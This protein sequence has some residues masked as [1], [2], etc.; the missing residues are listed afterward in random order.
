MKP[1]IQPSESRPWL[2][3][4]DLLPLA[5]GLGL[6][7][8]TLRYWDRLPDPVP[9]HFGLHNVPNGWT[10]KASI[11]W[12]IFGFPLVMW[13]SLWMAG[14]FAAPKDP[15][16]AALVTYAFAPLRGL[17]GLG[18]FVLGSLV[19]LIPVL[20]MQVF[21]PLFLLFFALLFSGIG[22]TV[23]KGYL[24]APDDVKRHWKWGIFYINPEDPRLW[25]PKYLGI[26]WTLNFSRP[27]AW[28][29]LVVLLLTP[30]L[31]ATLLPR[32]LN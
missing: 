4:W 21:W 14:R 28:V 27:I 30:I 25:V 1:S 5:G 3:D 12:M 16:R 20:G 6:L 11:P 32:V 15:Q 23:R 19:V 9:T 31:L 18:F 24:R 7:A 8:L 22:I 29:I 2:S 26:G 10:P 17:A 13:V